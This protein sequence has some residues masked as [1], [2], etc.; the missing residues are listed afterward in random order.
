[1]IPVLISKTVR[2]INVSLFIG[3]H[4]SL[5]CVDRAGILRCPHYCKTVAELVPLLSAVGRNRPL[6]GSNDGLGVAPHQCP[7]SIGYPAEISALCRSFQASSALSVLCQFFFDL[8]FFE[9]SRWCIRTNTR[10]QMCWK[11]CARIS[12]ILGRL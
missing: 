9:R 8:V 7:E 6:A 1:M 10:S 2:K 5:K 4:L 12:S 11:G 3:R